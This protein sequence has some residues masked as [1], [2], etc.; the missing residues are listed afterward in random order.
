MF[1]SF[2]KFCVKCGRTTDAL[3]HGMCTECYLKR[4]DLFEL[5]DI[6]IDICVKCGKARIKGSWTYPS[7]EIVAN[8]I[9]SRIKLLHA[10]EQPKTF[11]EITP[12][13]KIDYSAKI[14]VEGILEGTIVKQTKNDEFFLQKVSCDSCMKLVS[15]YREAII[16]LRAT[17]N[18]EADAMLEVTKQLLMNEQPKDSLSAPIKIMTEKNGHDLWIGSNRG[19]VKVARKLTKLYK[20]NL[21]VSKKQIGGGFGNKPVY[22]FTYSI[23]KK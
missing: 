1:M 14:T 8:E 20:T 3:V 22:R 15:N 16:Q 9:A 21:L 5:K 7:D 6:N 12:I 17:N 19:A 13:T 10:I 11:V 23:K 4:N 18:E 2:E